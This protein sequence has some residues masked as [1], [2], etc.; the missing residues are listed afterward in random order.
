MERALLGGLRG[1]PTAAPLPRQPPPDDG[2]QRPDAVGG[3]RQHHG[4]LGGGR[5]VPFHFRR[6]VQDVGHGVPGPGARTPRGSRRR[7]SR[8]IDRQRANGGIIRRKCDAKKKKR[9]IAFDVFA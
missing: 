8:D 1:V 5:A 7:P 3:G 6:R 4:A 2:V 9:R